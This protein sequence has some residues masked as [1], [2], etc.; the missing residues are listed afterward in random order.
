[1]VVFNVRGPFP[2]KLRRRPGGRFID[3]ETIA[4]FWS[5]CADL[6]EETGC[7]VFGVRA[8][9]GIVPAYVGQSTTGFKNE[10][11]ESHKLQHYHGALADRA[12][13]TPVMFFLVRTEGPASTVEASVDRL[14]DFLI[15][16][17]SDRNPSL[18]NV[19][20]VEWCIQGVVRSQP[21]PPS[22]AAVFFRRMMGL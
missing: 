2:I 9:R 22:D 20:R 1:M 3:V 5:Q 16:I 21:G 14:E 17:A 13:A 19:R 6:V 10:C 11:F 18:R 7:Y 15:Q 8:G 4:R 12:K